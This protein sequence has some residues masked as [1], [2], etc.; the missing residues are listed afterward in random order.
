[1]TECEWCFNMATNAVT[2]EEGNYHL[3]DSCVDE[4]IRLT[5]LTEGDTIKSLVRRSIFTGKPLV[6]TTPKG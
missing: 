3:C 5:L 6:I 2:I 1:M 4:A